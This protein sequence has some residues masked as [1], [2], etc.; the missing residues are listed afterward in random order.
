MAVLFNAMI[1]HSH[2]PDRLIHS[3]LVPLF[4]DKSRRV[5]DQANYRAIAQSTV[6]SMVL[7]LV[8][9]ERL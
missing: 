5:D 9:I 8:L 7:E 4:K 3:L 6:L 1:N 2:L